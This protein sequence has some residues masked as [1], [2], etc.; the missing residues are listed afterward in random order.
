MDIMHIAGKAAREGA[1]LLKNNGALPLK[2]GET[3]AVF[4]RAQFE[5]YKSG[6]GSG[7]MVN[8]PY[9]TNITDSLINLNCVNIDKEIYNSYKSYLAQN[10]P[11]HGDGT[12]AS[13]PWYQ[14]E[15]PVGE[16]MAQAAA[17]RAE[18]AVVVIGRTAGEDRDNYDGEGSFRLTETERQMLKN[19]TSAFKRTVLLFN[20]SNIMDM[21]F[22]NEI[23]PDAVMY[24]WQGG[25]E[26]GRAAA[27]L[28]C[29][30][31]SPCG[32]L[33]DTI[34]ESY[35]AYPSAENFGGETRNIYAEDIYV[36][37]RYFETFAKETVRYPFGFG[38]SYTTFDYFIESAQI[39]NGIAEISA[40]VTNTGGFAAREVIQLYV[41]AKGGKSDK[42][43]M[44]LAG[45]KKTG[46]LQPGE[47]ESIIIS[48][49]I[50]SHASY[51]DSGISGFKD[52]FVLESG[53]YKIYVGTSVRDCILAAV[54]KQEETECVQKCGDI[55]SPKI[56]FKR[57][58]A[59]GQGVE[60]EKVPS[61]NEWAFASEVSEIS[62]RTDED[63]SFDDVLSGKINAF[64]LASSLSDGDLCCLVRGEGMN[65]NKVRPGCGAA[66][67]G[68]SESLKARGIPAVAATDGP[69]GIRLDNGD[70]A[71]SVPIGTLLACTWDDELVSELYEAVGRELKERNADILLAPGVN[72]H[73]DPLCGRN[74][75]Y[76][77]ED[78]YL[79]GRMGAAVLKGLHGGGAVGTVKHFAANNQEKNRKVVNSVVSK[80][81]LREIYLKPFEIAVKSE[82]PCL[83]MTTYNP[84]NG[85]WNSSNY[86]LCTRLLR[87]EW[88]FDGIIMTD[89]WAYVCDIGK[90]DADTKNAAAMIKAGGD[91]YMVCGDAQSNSGEDNLAQALECG[92]L[93]RAELVRAGERIIK[94]IASIKK[95]V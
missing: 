13:E 76:F 36:G 40:R 23:N 86:E 94:F 70:G 47:S 14:S 80:R 12:W 65:S 27:E 79:S 30:L 84:L 32:K 88:G 50:K 62:K 5:Y 77:S 49:D 45:Y 31:S 66:F 7:G 25:Q 60:Y 83:V 75:E 10:P 91:L 22:E 42:P 48:F 3:A 35:R 17:S 74:F 82:A 53:E 33:S 51:D 72:I 81:A 34:A 38:L 26:G 19:I 20:T 8:A 18:T 56:D 63:L 24:I 15:M 46:L 37:Y 54:Y 39:R 11:D 67:G 16:E 4:G 58:K 9:V 28:L 93:S 78:P 90:N 92:K 43:A 61:K 64:D 55:L 95:Q 41:S 44:S 29:G 69:S 68:V 6:T 85:I 71:T 73:R 2:K 87:D 59:C 89:W 52:C 57:L 21:S 1:V